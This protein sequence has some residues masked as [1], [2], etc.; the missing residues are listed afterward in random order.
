MEML[1]GSYRGPGSEPRFKRPTRHH[2][3]DDNEKQREKAQSAWRGAIPMPEKHDAPPTL[4]LGE[5][6][7]F[8]GRAPGGIRWERKVGRDGM[9][10]SIMGLLAPPSAWRDAYPN[11]AG[12][13]QPSSEYRS[14]PQA[15]R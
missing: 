2:S 1:R 6:A 13:P 15:A 12:S 9:V 10:G 7:G 4:W 8:Y 5:K 3:K 14:T 11:L